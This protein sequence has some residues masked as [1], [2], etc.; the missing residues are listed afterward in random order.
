MYT[1]YIFVGI[2]ACLWAI[3]LLINSVKN[4]IT[5]WDFRMCILYEFRPSTQIAIIMVTVCYVFFTGLEGVRNLAHY[6]FRTSAI[7]F[8]GVMFVLAIVFLYHDWP[9]LHLALKSLSDLFLV[10]WAILVTWIWAPAQPGMMLWVFCALTVGMFCCAFVFKIVLAF[11]FSYYRRIKWLFLFMSIL[12]YA[13]QGIYMSMLI[14]LAGN[15]T[16]TGVSYIPT[17][18][19]MAPY[20]MPSSN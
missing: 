11:L 18:P 14:L 20:S 13:V 10:I 1:T 7:V 9:A 16:Y 12:D 19:P 17:Q 6:R 5:F 15:V 3:L 2:W 8:S 4:T